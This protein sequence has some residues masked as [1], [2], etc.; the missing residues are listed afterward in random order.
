MYNLELDQDKYFECFLKVQG[1]SLKK[2]KINL[3]IEAND[4]DIKFRGSINESGKVTGSK[5]LFTSSRH[6]RSGTKID[7]PRGVLIFENLIRCCN[8][9]S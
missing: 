5:T 9:S 6:N 4:L 1:T 2:S 3:V 7:R 8:V